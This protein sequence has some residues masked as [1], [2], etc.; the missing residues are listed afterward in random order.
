MKNKVILERP[1]RQ[2]LKLALFLLIIFTVIFAGTLLLLRAVNAKD[3]NGNV[4]EVTGELQKIIYVEE[5]NVRVEVN[6]NTYIVNPLRRV[7]KN[8]NLEELV[9]Q[10]VTLYV[11]QTQ[12]GK[13]HLVLGLKH[14]DNV[15]VDYNETIKLAL[16]ENREVMIV[17][18]VLTGVLFVATCGVYVWRLRL[19]PTKEYDLA[20]KYSEFSM[21]RQ[22]SCPA[23]KKLGIFVVA[24]LA[25][26]M[27]YG[28][29]LALVGTL[30]DS[31]AA[32]I[33]VGV[34]GGVI[35]V[36]CTAL[37]FVVLAWVIKKEREFYAK[38]FPF[39]FTDV[40][41]IPMRKKFKQQLQ[42]EISNERALH[43]HRY[44]EGGN[45][46]TVEFSENGLKF[47]DLDMLYGKLDTTDEVF[48]IP[49]A[50][51]DA[52]CL[53][54][55]IDYQTLNFEALPFYRQKDHPLT[56]VIKSRLSEAELPDALKPESADEFRNDV[57][58]VLDSN[59]LATLRRFN[60]PV[61]NLDYILDNKEKLIAENCTRN[62]RKSN[63]K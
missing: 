50:K 43:P 2:K 44:G 20:Q 32:Q 40:S 5:D 42:S 47:Y 49:D 46:Y 55:T 23:Y 11:S 41:H 45:G 35:F 24:Y 53:L 15:L 34:S 22:P 17:F 6:G 38:N 27:L 59:L 12:V 26:T 3:Y 1:L 14:G 37:L 21:S 9:H 29:S 10:T 8:L 28:V 16:E 63:T 4:N 60:V 39:D 56:V 48:G 30:T 25:Y 61:E 51:L 62:G 19:S 52:Q 57:H 7:N 18:G 13:M 33:A 54:C 31:V 58:I 36:A